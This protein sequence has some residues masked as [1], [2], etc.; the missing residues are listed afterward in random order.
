MKTFNEAVQRLKLDQF[1]ILKILLFFLYTRGM[2]QEINKSVIPEGMVLVRGGIFLMGSTKGEEDE[3]PL[4]TVKIDDF[5]MG[6]YEVTH[7][8]YLAFLNA[9]KVDSTGW[10]EDKEYIDINDCDCA[11]GYKNGKFYFKG[12]EYAL[13]PDCPVIEVTWYGAAAYC[14]WRGGRL[15]SEAEWEYAARGG[16]KSRGYIFSGG[17]STAKVSW[18]GNNSGGKTHPVG[19]KR[20]NELGIYDM[21]GNVWEWCRDWYDEHFY[22]NSSSQD[23]PEPTSAQVRVGRGGSWGSISNNLRST[24]RHFYIPPLSSNFVGFR[25]VYPSGSN[26]QR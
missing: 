15:P 24:N 10:V 7:Q 19:T 18:Y 16:Q 21:S 23:Q 11:I 3:M 4:H 26:D 22:K 6:K 1:V 8:E 12:S 5:F 14:Q 17:N 25:I 13:T 9:T 20:P 2:A